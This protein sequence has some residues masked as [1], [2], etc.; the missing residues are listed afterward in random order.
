MRD[1]TFRP[2]L[3]FQLHNFYLTEKQKLKRY[4]PIQPVNDSFF[5]IL[6]PTYLWSSFCSEPT[7]APLSSNQKSI[8]FGMKKSIY[9]LRTLFA[10]FLFLFNLTLFA[11]NQTEICTNGLDDDA[12]G[13]VDCY[14]PDCNCMPEPDCTAPA[15]DN[16]AAQLQWRSQPKLYKSITVPIVANMNPKTDNMPEIIVFPEDTTIGGS[17]T[18]FA[19][20]YRGDG[21]NAHQPDI[22]HIADGIDLAW[23]IPAAVGDLN[24]DGSPELVLIS[25]T[26]HILVYR[27]YTPGA[28]SAMSLWLKSDLPISGSDFNARVKR[29]HLADL[30]GDGLAEIVGGNSIF[31]LNLSNPANA[32]L[33]RVLFAG[34]SSP[35]GKFHDGI[36]YTDVFNAM[37]IADLLT[38]ADC[39]GDP[40]C[41][42]L[43]IAAG[44]AIYSV[45]MDMNDGDSVQ[46]KMVRNLTQM[47]P[48]TSWGDGFTSVA[49][50]DLDGVPDVIV[51]SQRYHFTGETW[52]M[53]IWNKNG[54]LKFFPFPKRTGVAVPSI[55]NIFD[56]TQYGF[57]KDL[58]EII[59]DYED[60]LVCF[61]LN[62]ATLNPAQPWWWA[63]TSSN[64]Q[65]HAGAYPTFDF[66][67]DGQLEIVFIDR[68]QLRILYG[69]GWPYPPG[70]DADRNWWKT[71]VGQ[72]IG[73]GHPVVADA[74]NDGQAEIVMTGQDGPANYSFN[75]LRVYESALEPWVGCRP[76]WHQFNYNPVMINDDLSLPKKQQKHWLEFLSGS[77]KHLR[78]NLFS[79]VAPVR[80]NGQPLYPTPDAVAELDSS[81]CEQQTLHLTLRV[82]NQGSTALQKNLPLQFYRTDPTSTAALPY[83]TAFLL[84]EIIRPDSCLR[85]EI[86]LP[87]PADGKLWG[88]LN[89]DGS[90][91]SPLT[92][93]IDLPLSSLPECDYA[94]NLFSLN[95]AA[96]GGM[97]NL[98][99]DTVLCAT[100][101]KLLD[102]GSN[103]S[104]Y[105]WHDGS[106][107]STYAAT[108]PG[109]Y[110]V[111]A[112]DICGNKFTDT[113]HISPAPPL[114]GA[115]TIAF[116]PGQSVT[117][118]GQ[119][120]TQPGTVVV[121]KPAPGGCDSV[122]TYTL[123]WNAAPE[124]DP[125][126][127]KTIGC[128]KFEILGISQNLK[129]QKTYRMR[130]TNNCAGKL[131]YVTFQ[132]PAGMTAKAPAT[133][134]TYTSPDGR[135]YEV[136]N[137]N[138]SPTHSIRFKSVG[139][140]ISGGQSDIFE[141]TLPAQADMAFIHASVRLEPQQFFETHLNVFGCTVEQ[142]A[143][144]PESSAGR[145]ADDLAETTSL[146]IFPNPASAFILIEKSGDTQVQAQLVSA[147]GQVF[148]TMLLTDVR[149]RVDVSGLPAGVWFLRTE[150]GGVARFVRM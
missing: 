55:A 16:I 119:T 57:A 47:T 42:G 79:Q 118:N 6:V 1:S 40:D 3:L 58:P 22:V 63:L 73:L 117:L 41:D 5:L 138:H 127:E 113:I 124:N 143:N 125:C 67:G 132:L 50:V 141:Y 56:D 106:A 37:S 4:A 84:P 142:T 29:P 123:V 92:L 60:Q 35:D 70:V 10:G 26:G 75:Y 136:R 126:D 97:L 108:G 30:D 91:V 78:N 51:V 128:M 135:V 39:N 18:R 77:G 52:G 11:Q 25:F 131:N 93:S 104:R 137:P 81:Y 99:P 69:G 14:D 139:T 110:Q 32:K 49:D 45:D 145:S 46:I 107:N 86:Q 83:S 38:P 114:T 64:Y 140:G 147:T 72:Q 129:K 88:L 134:A 2:Q 43:E 74:D 111:D 122:I 76:V 109:T 59:L 33:N 121:T 116:P 80:Q 94:N 28:P 95:A 65:F 120:Y 146:E 61:N 82:C 112:W 150:D 100:T 34:L 21:S 54:L 90:A 8:A 68:D 15:P 105:R 144:R 85:W 7:R 17:A 9:L 89:D 48:Q 66:N 27:N 96:F 133:G 13:Y 19:H 103:F 115:Q 36:V 62:A 20:I 31:Q 130:V 102:A 87:L 98:G 53:Y 44:R 149:T 101:T 23:T 24:A 12:D 148:Q 71:P